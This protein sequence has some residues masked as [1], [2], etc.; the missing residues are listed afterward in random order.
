MKDF[1]SLESEVAGGSETCRE[2][3]LVSAPWCIACKVM[4]KWFL[5]VRI[6]RVECRVVGIEE[7]KDKSISSVCKG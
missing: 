7:I 5:N 6:P 3:F 1:E 4:K 2:I